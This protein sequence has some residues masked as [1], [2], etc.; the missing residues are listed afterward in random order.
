MGVRNERERERVHLLEKVEVPDLAQEHQ[1]L[2]E[3]EVLV[4]LLNHRRDL[5]GI[6][7]LALVIVIHQL[8]RHLRQPALEEAGERPCQGEQ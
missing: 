2:R 4:Q 5:I 8:I 1:S 3:D 7:A 6:D